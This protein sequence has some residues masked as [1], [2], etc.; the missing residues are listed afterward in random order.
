MFQMLGIISR[1]VNKKMTLKTSNG[2]NQ[3]HILK[4]D[5]IPSPTMPVCVLTD[6]WFF[7]SG[8]ICFVFVFNH[9]DVRLCVNGFPSFM[10]LTIIRSSS[11]KC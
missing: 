6:G 3:S 2:T 8:Y 10:Q 7:L 11:F 1:L 5:G 9:V 4:T